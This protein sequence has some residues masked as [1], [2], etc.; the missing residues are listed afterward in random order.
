MDSA[1]RICSTLYAT[2]PKPIRLFPSFMTSSALPRL[3]P[4]FQ[5]RQPLTAAGSTITKI[6]RDV[7]PA[8]PGPAG[9]DR[10]ATIRH[11]DRRVAPASRVAVARGVHTRGDGVYERVLETGLQPPR[12]GASR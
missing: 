4:C 10:G 3:S 6:G 2:N 9:E 8:A 12:G 5:V 11:D 1:R 7:P